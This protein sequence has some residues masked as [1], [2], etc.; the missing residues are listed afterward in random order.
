MLILFTLMMPLFNFTRYLYNVEYILFFLF[1]MPVLQCNCLQ[2]TV[3]LFRCLDILHLRIKQGLKWSCSKKKQLKTTTKNWELHK[4]CS[5]K[6][7]V[8]VL[9]ELVTKT[10]IYKLSIFLVT[11][12]T[13][14]LQQSFIT[15][16]FMYLNCKNHTIIFFQIKT[17]QCIVF[18][19]DIILFVCLYCLVQWYTDHV[20]GCSFTKQFTVY[21]LNNRYISS[22]IDTNQHGKRKKNN[23]NFADSLIQLPI[24][25]TFFWFCLLF[26]LLYPIYLQRSW[27]H[28]SMRIYKLKTAQN[29]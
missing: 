9:L 29:E 7:S 26:N 16:G 21:F 12:F 6:I 2:N 19:D 1:Q 24:D 4:H 20:P 3:K 23:R 18:M 11:L 5:L 25:K 15:L 17:L 10:C 13:F 8:L 28:A 27:Y 14:L 22:F